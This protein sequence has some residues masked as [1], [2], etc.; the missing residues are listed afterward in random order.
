MTSNQDIL[1]FLKAEQEAQ[2][3]AKEDDKVTRARERQEDRENILEMIKIGVQREVKS[4]MKAVDERVIQ[5]EIVNQELTNKL[6]SLVQEM[7]QLKT[8]LTDNAIT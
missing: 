6:N 4:A 3:K 5:Q 1:A 8:S 2:T 7:E